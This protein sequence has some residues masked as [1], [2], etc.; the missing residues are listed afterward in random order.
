[1][2]RAR[3]AE[4]SRMGVA[5]APGHVTGLFVPQLSGRDPRSRGSIGAGLVLDVGVRARAHWSP[6]KPRRL[7]IRADV[8]RPLPITT[9]VA[10]R[11]W[12]NR[13]G[14]LEVDLVHELPIG[15]GFGMSAAGALAT[16]L[17]VG[18]AVDVPRQRCI[19]VAHLADLLHA[20]G[21]G[22]VSAILGGGLEIRRS[23]GVPP[24]GKV[25]HTAVGARIL[26]GTMGAPLPSSHLL[27]RATFLARVEVAGI[28]GL[29]RLLRRPSLAN[30][31]TE[32]I[33]FGDSLALAPPSLRKF[34]TDMRGQDIPCLQAM[35]GRSFV[36]IPE[37]R[38]T[39]RYLIEALA[40]RGWPAVEIGV[41]RRGAWGRR[42]AVP[43]P[44]AF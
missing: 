11:L 40:R 28:P 26:L 6:H 17:A 38:Q 1:M 43:S 18:A 14:R 4:S 30:F 15:Q 39:R 20:G 34:L 42:G 31:L 3:R 12:G 25:S 44:K 27:S 10:S 41:A 35:F 21:L 24:W 2:V 16:S 13:E 7:V 33:T 29:A 8:P 36:A 32:S 9:E 5:F 37:S 19:E 22:G 23:P